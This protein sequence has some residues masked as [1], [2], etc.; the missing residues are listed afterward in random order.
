[1]YVVCMKLI[2]VYKKE[3]MREPKPAYRSVICGPHRIASSRHE[4]VQVHLQL[5]NVL[6]M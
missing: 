2:Y 3:E 5:A 1:M 6:H 4:Q